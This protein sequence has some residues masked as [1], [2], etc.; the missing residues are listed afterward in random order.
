[1]PIR[2]LDSVHQELLDNLESSGLVMD[3]AACS[4]AA[5]RRFTPSSVSAVMADSSAAGS[6]GL[7]DSS[8]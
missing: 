2:P 6:G 1:M 8:T 7:A 5:V 3:S 4:R